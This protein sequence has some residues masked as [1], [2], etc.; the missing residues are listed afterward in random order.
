MRLG[1]MQPYFFPYLGYFQLLNAVDKFVIYDNIQYTK[2]GWVNRNRIL[3]SGKDTLFTIPLRKDSDYLN[4][5]DR[6]IVDELSS[7]WKTKLL[8]QIKSNY[9][10]SMYFEQFY[11]VFENIINFENSNLFEYVDNSIRKICEY[12]DIDTKLIIS[13][14]L[15]EEGY[16]HLK[17][18]HRVKAICGYLGA[19]VYVN[20]IGGISLYS[21][22][23]FDESSIQLRFIEMEKGV[24]YQQNCA[25]F[26]S[27]LSIIDVLMWNNKE[28][29]RQMLSQYTLR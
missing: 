27:D 11:S 6:Y 23:S 14:E 3:S 16:S 28:T 19:E 29:C 12:M 20:S 22:D 4:I 2:K 5:S 13:S 7:K 21:K 17:G 24:R 1:I 15:P 25:I 10:K 18:E 8:N 26:I 9:K